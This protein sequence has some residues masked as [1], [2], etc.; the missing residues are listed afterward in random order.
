LLAEWNKDA[1]KDTLST[2]PEMRSHVKGHFTFSGLQLTVY[3][4]NNTRRLPREARRS[5]PEDTPL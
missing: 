5:A 4:G 2:T 1:K 3:K